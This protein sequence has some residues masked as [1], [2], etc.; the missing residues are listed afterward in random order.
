M[1]LYFTYPNNDAV[2]Y[3]TAMLPVSKVKANT[4]IPTIENPYTAKVVSLKNK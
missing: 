1:L 4:H 2:T 3:T